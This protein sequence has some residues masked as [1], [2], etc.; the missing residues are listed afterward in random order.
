MSESRD[1]KNVTIATSLVTRAPAWVLF[2]ILGPVFYAGLEQGLLPAKVRVLLDGV[3]LI[4]W[5]YPLTVA[6]IKRLPEA[7][8]LSFPRFRFHLLYVPDFL[9]APCMIQF[10]GRR[11]RPSPCC[12]SSP[13]EHSVRDTTSEAKRCGILSRSG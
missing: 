10:P 5:L 6:L 3:F 2:I 4:G 1:L 8:M 12:G 7:P 11:K 13:G 9:S